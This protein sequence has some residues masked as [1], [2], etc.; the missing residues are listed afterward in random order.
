MKT[1]ALLADE[2]GA[3]RLTERYR[4]RVSISPLAGDFSSALARLHFFISVAFA[5]LFLLPC[6]KSHPRFR[7]PVPLLFSPGG[8]ARSSRFASVP[9]RRTHN[10]HFTTLLAAPS[11][12]TPRPRSCCRPAARHGG[13]APRRQGAALR[14]CE[15]YHF[16]P[17]RNTSPLSFCTIS[18]PPFLAVLLFRLFIRYN[19][20]F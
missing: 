18:A 1:R 6:P 16:C 12:S 4:G 5:F 2:D 9:R 10:S 20:L 3:S 11:F 14:H 19:P 8:A 15:A 7:A 13:F 17:P